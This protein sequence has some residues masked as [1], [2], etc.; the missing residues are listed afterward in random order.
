[1]VAE[2]KY[3]DLLGVSPDVSESD[4]KKAVRAAPFRRPIANLN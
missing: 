3:Y 4:M 2:T 1:M